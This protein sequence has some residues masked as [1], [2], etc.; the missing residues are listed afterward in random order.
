VTV[1]VVFG[2]RGRGD[3][4]E[5]Y[6]DDAVQKIT[7]RR[8]VTGW[9]GRP[10]PSRSTHHIRQAGNNETMTLDKQIRGVTSLNLN[11][12]QYDTPLRAAVAFV[13]MPCLST[14]PI[15]LRQA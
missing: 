9:R 3:E 13:L 10:I 14:T 11:P 1:G 6:C 2:E 8:G 5:Y 15:H 12:G 4:E 7:R